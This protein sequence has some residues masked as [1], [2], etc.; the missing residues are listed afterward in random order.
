[1]TFAADAAR[2]HRLR[3]EHVPVIDE[4]FALGQQRHEMGGYK[5][6]SAIDT[7]FAVLRI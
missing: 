1:M 7:R 3:L 5:I 4:H 2:L 6:T